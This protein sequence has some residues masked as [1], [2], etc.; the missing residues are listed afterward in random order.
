MAL[1]AIAV[2]PD[3]GRD[4]RRLVSHATVYSNLDKTNTAERIILAASQLGEHRFA[5]M[6]DSYHF[7]YRIIRRLEED[8]HFIPTGIVFVADTPRSET[9]EDTVDFSRW[10]EEQGAAV[11][12]VLGGDGT[13]RAAAKGITKTPL[14]SLSTGT[15]NVFPEMVE[16]TVAGMAA[17]ALADKVADPSNCGSRCKRIEVYL[18]RELVDIALVDAV[19]SG[20]TYIGSK[21]IWNRDDIQRV[22]ACQCHPATIGFSSLLGSTLTI[23]PDDDFGAAAECVPGEP[24]VRASLAAGVISPFRLERIQTLPLDNMQIWKMDNAGTLAL[25]GEREV[26]WDCGDEVGLKIVRNGPIRLDLRKVL[27]SAQRAGYFRL[28]PSGGKG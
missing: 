8:L 24:N 4:I 16:G 22:V 11:L 23:L 13:C 5:I 26:R 10:A 14:I 6:P 17:S 20:Y 18:N 25:D 21:A 15:N 12:I 9:A 7:G 1:I 2:N 27:V 3:S 19:F 28:S